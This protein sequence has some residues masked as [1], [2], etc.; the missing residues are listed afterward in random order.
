MRPAIHSV[1]VYVSITAM[2]TILSPQI[3]ADEVESGN[4]KTITNIGNSSITTVIKKKGLECQTG[5]TQKCEQGKPCFSN[6][7]IDGDTAKQ[8]WQLLEAHGIKSNDATGEYVAT[9]SE[10]MQCYSNE[11]KF[12]CVIGYDA[13]ANIMT[14]PNYC[15]PE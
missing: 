1:M 8:L 13:I 4:A 14:A 15:D 12:S 2:A 9:N 10:A 11:G 6:I 5:L 7:E 3:W